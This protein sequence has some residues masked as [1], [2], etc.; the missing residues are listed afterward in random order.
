MFSRCL[1]L[2]T[3]ISCVAPRLVYGQPIVSAVE[4]FRDEGSVASDELGHVLLQELNCV[5]CHT[6][7]QLQ[8]KQAP[9]LTEV[10][11][12]VKADYLQR[13]IGQPHIEK[14]GATMPSLFTGLPQEQREKEVTALVHFL[15]TLGD[16]KPPQGYASYGS[17]RRGQALFHQVGCVACHDARTEGSAALPT[18]VPLGVLEAKYTLPSLFKFL[19]DPLHTRPSGRMPSLNLTS[20]EADDIATYLLPAGLEKPGIEYQYFRGEW[21]RFPDLSRMEP[22]NSGVAASLDLGLAG[23]GRY[24]AM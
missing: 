13:F 9:V 3:V 14:P 21:G 1:L 23:R 18:S 8:G 19:L 5:A 22:R 6:D 7:P 20:R 17:R 2:F 16:G 10:S 4:R 12:R 24:Y 11:S 15:M